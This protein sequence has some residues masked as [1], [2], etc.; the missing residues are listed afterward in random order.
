MESYEARYGAGRHISRPGRHRRSG[1]GVDDD[2]GDRAVGGS[3]GWRVAQLRC[4]SGE[5]AYS[6]L[7]QVN[8]SNFN[9]LEV[10]WRFKTDALGPRPEF[11]LQSTPLVVNGVM[12]TTAGTRRAV[13]ALNPTTGE[14]LWMHSMNEGTRGEAAPRQLSGRGLA[15]WTDG[16]E[17]RI[18][19]V[20]P[21]Y[22]MIAL[23]AKTGARG[24]GF[25]KRR[26]RRSEDGRR[27]GDRSREA[28]RLVCTPRRSSRRTSSSSAPRICPAARR[29]ARPTRRVS[30]AATTSRR[31][32]GCGSSTR[33]PGRANSAT[34]RGKNDSWSY[35]GNA[36]VWATDDDRRGAR[37]CLP[38]GG[39]ADRR[40]LRRQ[41]P[42]QRPV[43]REPRRARSEYRQAQVALPARASRASGTWTSRARRSSWIIIVDG[44]RDQGDRD[45]RPS[46]AGSTPSIAPPARRCG[47]LRNGRSRRATCLASGTRRRSRS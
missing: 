24:S 23:D 9:K 39:A 6:P 3:E 25:G 22:Q 46:K 7:D 12:Y 33:F 36:G 15:Y 29:R 21:G 34:T 13:V 41:P 5:H 17:E 18:V 27:S 44:Q 42:G 37:D 10:A 14:M 2:A 30:S 47:R 31:A 28:A 19:Y 16:R 4:R 20:T 1:D 26:R 38:A 40:L 35:T 8:A 45:S 11:N 43:R 32:S